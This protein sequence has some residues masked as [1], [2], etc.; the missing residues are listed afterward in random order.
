MCIPTETTLDIVA[1]V[2][3][4]TGDNILDG[5]GQ[6]VTVVRKTSSERWSIKESKV[7]LVFVEF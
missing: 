5:T 1:S 2:V 6:Q 4:I 3:S 7:G